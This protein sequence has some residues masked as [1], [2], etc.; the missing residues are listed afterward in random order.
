MGE[1][2]PPGRQP[3]TYAQVSLD[4][5]VTWLRTEAPPEPRPNKV[6]VVV[7][8]GEILD[9]TQAP[10]TI[11]GD[12]TSELIRRAR[13][14]ESVK[15]LVLRVDSPGGSAFASELIL[16][17]LERFQ[18]TDRPV[19]VSM[20]SVAASGGYWISMGADEIWASPT[21]LTGSI[22]VGFVV[23]TVPRALD[24]AGVHVDGVGTTEL[25]G[26]LDVTRPVGESMKGF[27]ALSARHLYADFVA[28]VAEHR[29]RSVDEVESAAQGRV[30]TGSDA[31]DRGL[32]D[33]L[34]SLPQAIE[35]A[36]ELA[37]LESD[38][39]VLDYVEQQL[40]FVETLMLSLTA[41]AVASVGGLVD[42]PRWPAA[43]TQ[44][45]ESTLEPM[46]FI[47]RFNDPRGIYAY[48][49]CETQ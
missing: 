41:K 4:D 6:A 23:P 46:A 49:F 36:A 44:A 29:S 15:A 38:G 24:W 16:R 21:T 14:D 48:C 45:L 7:A 13:A 34:G 33:K 47:E 2:P 5:Y 20:G 9:G 39:Y 30:W 12:S 31:L 1:D 43:V 40:G 27:I 10:G 19:V 35:S 37:G 42:L 28:K 26:A 22:G 8:S 3:D 18:E 11:G 32:V 17:E 25:A